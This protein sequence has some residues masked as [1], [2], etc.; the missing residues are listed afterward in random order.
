MKKILLIFI[1]FFTSFEEDRVF[2][3]SATSIIVIG[4]KVGFESTSMKEVKQIFR[5]KYS[6]WKNNEQVTIV[7]PSSKSESAIGVA[8]IIYGTSVSSM[9]RYWLSL[10]FQGRFSAPIFLETDQEIIAYIKKTPG[11]IGVISSD[12]VGVPKN[13]TINVTN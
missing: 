6:S 4:N 13:L 5:G 7:L 8:L 10:V 3:Q 9:Q 2:A 11:A 12:A 1:L